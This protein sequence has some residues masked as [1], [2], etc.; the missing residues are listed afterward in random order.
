[1]R[2]LK[3]K[4][5]NKKSEIQQY[6][7]FPSFIWPQ[8]LEDKKPNPLLAPKIEEKK[9]EFCL[10]VLKND[11]G[12]YFKRVDPFP[13]IWTHIND[14]FLEKDEKYKDFYKADFKSEIHIESFPYY[15]CKICFDEK[16]K[17]LSND[18]NFYAGKKGEDLKFCEN[19]FVQFDLISDKIYKDIF[20]ILPKE[21]TKKFTKDYLNKSL[22]VLE[23]KPVKS[24]ELFGRQMYLHQQVFNSYKRYD[25]VILANKLN[26]YKY[27]LLNE[28]DSSLYRKYFFET[29]QEFI[30]IYCKILDVKSTTEAITSVISYATL[31][32]DKKAQNKNYLILVDHLK[33]FNNN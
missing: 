31:N 11:Q 5:N 14:F 8:Y 16:L 18:I 27:Y 17:L 10:E 33:K 25:L 7:K 1:M 23:G 32:K 21:V 6:I 13:L 30:N 26:E 9:P 2:V 28:E 24:K 12:Y 15:T 22:K 19:S 20:E 4:I 3:F 29:L